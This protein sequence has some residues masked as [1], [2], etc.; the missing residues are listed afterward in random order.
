[1]TVQPTQPRVRF[2]TRIEVYA[3]GDAKPSAYLEIRPGYSLQV[4][5]PG[6]DRHCYLGEDEFLAL[7]DA[8][9]Q[10]RAGG[11]GT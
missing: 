6:N 11:T 7:A 10:H 4:V 1:M 3:A 8:L 9:R 5:E 2:S